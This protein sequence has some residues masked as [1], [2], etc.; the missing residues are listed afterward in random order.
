MLKARRPR[1]RGLRSRNC[2]GGALGGAVMVR[3][4]RGL[5]G[6]KE[7]TSPLTGVAG[8][9]LVAQAGLNFS[10]AIDIPGGGSAGSRINPTSRTVCL[11]VAC[12]ARQA[13]PTGTQTT[14]VD[15]RRG[16]EMW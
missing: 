14:Y 3:R 8:S 4:V 5:H 7:R 9:P 10:V 15:R 2:R 1:D 11:P 13:L 16:S 6:I 12:R